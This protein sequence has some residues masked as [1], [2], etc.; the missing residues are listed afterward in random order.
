MANFTQQKKRNTENYVQ[1]EE[2]ARVPQ[3]QQFQSRAHSIPF[4]ISH[5]FH[6]RYT[7]WIDGRCSKANVCMGM[8]AAV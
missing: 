4:I 5:Y 3:Q 1:C 8:N 6:P 2:S 7:R